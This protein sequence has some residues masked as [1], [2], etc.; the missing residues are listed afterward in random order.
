MQTEQQ[1][2]AG[3]TNMSE[4]PATTNSATESGSFGPPCIDVDICSDSDTESHGQIDDINDDEHELFAPINWDFPNHANDQMAHHV[5]V[6]STS[7][8]E[9]H[10]S[11]I[12]RRRRRLI[13]AVFSDDDN[14]EVYSRRRREWGSGEGFSNQSEK[15]Q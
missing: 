10:S 14:Q 5:S 11:P 4:A 9:P 6:P 13:N 1:K 12:V 8:A 3:G 2:L 7:N 15:N